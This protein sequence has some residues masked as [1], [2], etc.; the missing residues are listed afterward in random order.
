MVKRLRSPIR[1]FG[2]KGMMKSKIMPFVTV[3]DHDRYVEPFGGGAS[4]LIAKPPVGVETYNDIDS[5]VVDFFKVIAD[6]DL[7]ERFHRRVGLLPY[8]RELLVSMRA[9]GLQRKAFQCWLE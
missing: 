3:W 1:W 7:F 4:I 5:A 6:V 8:S 9:S 2:G